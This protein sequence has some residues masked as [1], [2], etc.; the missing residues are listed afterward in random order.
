M[1]RADIFLNELK[2]FTK[3]G[4]FPNLTIIYLPNDHT[5][6]DISA[7]GYLADNDLAL[8]R[9]VEG[10]SKSPFWPSTCIFVNEDDPQAGL[11]H[12][13]GHRSLCLV[14]SPY[15]KRG[16]VVHNFYNQPSV[17]HTIEQMLGVSPMNQMD[18]TG[19]LMTA[20]F[21]N[22]PDLRA[23]AALPNNIPLADASGSLN[24][25][26]RQSAFWRRASRNIRFAR[27][28]GN[29]EDA[30][31]RLLWAATRGP[32]VP[33]PAQFAGAHGR[34]LKARGLIFAGESKTTG[35]D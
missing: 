27:P 3:T 1:V 6:G 19:P 9:I 7:R 34:G 32:N 31:N 18:G 30:F 33:Y 29:D 12:V 4:A 26:R 13:D 25:L 11:D 10:L 35:D 23:Y 14:I 24:R 5:G 2:T 22:T 15:T 28:D 8:G 21:A 17:L 16:A 20:C